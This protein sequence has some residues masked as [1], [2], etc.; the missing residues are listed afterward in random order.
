[1]ATPTR[2]TVTDQEVRA[3]FPSKINDLTPF[4]AAA[5]VR[6]STVDACMTAAGYSDEVKKQ[7]QTWLAAHLAASTRDRQATQISG[8]DGTNTQFG[9]TLGKGLESTFYG[10]QVIAFDVQGC[11]VASDPAGRN[12]VGS[13]VITSD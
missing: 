4:I 2:T 10:Q 8:P 3:I 7:I 5:A 11:L 6:M 1:M 13:W 12:G 9:G